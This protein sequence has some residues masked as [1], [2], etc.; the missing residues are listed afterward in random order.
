MSDSSQLSV[1]T[2]SALF[3]IAITSLLSQVS[4]YEL[5]A[6]PDEIIINAEPG[7]EICR[8]LTIEA[9]SHEVRISTKWSPIKSRALETFAYNPADFG[10]TVTAP[11]LLTANQKNLNV[12]IEVPDIYAYH[13]VIMIEDMSRIAGLGVW[14]TINRDSSEKPPKQQ[15]ISNPVK[16]TKQTITGS[17]IADAQNTSN[18]LQS[19]LIITTFFSSLL[20]AFLLLRLYRTK[21][22]RNI[23]IT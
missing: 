3:V 4:A 21:R 5:S 20:L 6:T 17:A 7:E 10:I 14:L 19:Y 9:G 18:N 8:S 11:S 13:G 2:F 15:N 12:C 23:Y 22:N 1:K 16:K